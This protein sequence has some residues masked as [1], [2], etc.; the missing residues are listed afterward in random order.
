MI[1]TWAWR[2]LKHTPSYRASNSTKEH[3]TILRTSGVDDGSRGVGVVETDPDRGRVC[4]VCAPNNA[5]TQPKIQRKICARNLSIV[6]LLLLNLH[7]LVLR[8]SNTVE[9]LHE[10]KATIKGS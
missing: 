1:D 9:P 6:V 4:C 5:A 2:L 8:V 7:L 10:R 3:R